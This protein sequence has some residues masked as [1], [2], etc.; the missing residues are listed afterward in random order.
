M[1]AAERMI[2]KEVAGVT[3]DGLV[4]RGARLAFWINA[5]NELVA[6]GIAALGL[7]R[8]VWE[9]SDLFQRIGCRVGE[10]TFT[11]DEIEHGVLRGNRPS[12]LSTAPPFPAGVPRRVHAVVPVDPRIHYA[13]NCGAR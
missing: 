12:P 6:G 7:R 11:A 8:S 9:V 10:M 1:S 4:T 5:Y 13:L 2:L 3:L